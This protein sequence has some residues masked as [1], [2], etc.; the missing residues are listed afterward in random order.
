M[1]FF[2][3][4]WLYFD[5]LSSRTILEVFL[6]QPTIGNEDQLD[7][8]VIKWVKF[9]M[10]KNLK[11][12]ASKKHEVKT[13][14][15]PTFSDERNDV[16]W[17]HIPEQFYRSKSKKIRIECFFY[18]RSDTTDLKIGP[19]H[20]SLSGFITF[21]NVYFSYIFYPNLARAP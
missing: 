11:S 19:K 4:S 5:F 2:D 20:I 16:H 14:I 6:T 3:L 17:W 7:Y 15:T 12:K 1:A 9:V 21:I 18:A 10:A 8:D 13:L